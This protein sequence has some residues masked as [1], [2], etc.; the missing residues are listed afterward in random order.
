MVHALEANGALTGPG[1]RG[2]PFPKG[3][4]INVNLEYFVDL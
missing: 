2:Y 3:A 4:L 1:S